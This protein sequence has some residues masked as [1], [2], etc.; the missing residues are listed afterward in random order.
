MTVSGQI[1]TSFSVGITGS[2]TNNFDGD[3]TSGIYIFGAQF[4]ELSF[5]TSYIP[6]SGSTVTRSADAANNS[7]SSDLINSTEGVLYVEASALANDGTSRR[8]SLNDGT[9]S[10]KV[11]IE[12]DETANRIR[13]SIT[14]GGSAQT[15]T[16]NATNLLQFNKIAVKYKQD[17]FAIWLNG[18][19]V[20][21]DT[22][23]NAPIGLS[24][25]VKKH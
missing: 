25:L 3:G 21:T 9:S 1:F 15:L 8:I 2:E 17:D 13:A 18:V 12:Y 16:Y 11:N 5:P 22:S 24:E 23:G 20:V 4:E 14:S 7:G 6:T 10:N 19:E